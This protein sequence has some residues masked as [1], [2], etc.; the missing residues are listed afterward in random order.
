MSFLN[1][2]GP[3]PQKIKLMPNGFNGEALSCRPTT[4][5]IR[6]TWRQECKR[7]AGATRT[8]LDRNAI[9]I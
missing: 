3:E 4:P 9:M 6:V 2:N 8:F 1:S 7:D 5:I